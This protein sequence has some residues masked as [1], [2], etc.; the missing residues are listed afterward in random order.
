MS[1][2]KYHGFQLYTKP[3]N[4]VTF[5][6]E[7]EDLLAYLPE[8]CWPNML[9]LEISGPRVD[10]LAIARAS[11]SLRKLKANGGEGDAFEMLAH[12]DYWCPFIQDITL[13]TM[14]TPLRPFTQADYEMAADM[15]FNFSYL[16]HLSLEGVKIDDKGLHFLLSKLADAPITTFNVPWSRGGEA[17]PTKLQ[18]MLQSSLINL[19]YC[20]SHNDGFEGFDRVQDLSVC[21][22]SSDEFPFARRLDTGEFQ[23]SHRVNE[24]GETGRQAFFRMVKES[25][26]DEEREQYDR[27][28][29]GNYS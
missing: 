14:R 6:F 4:R 21:T 1:N 3:E 27:W 17:K 24:A 20:I 18:T 7:T 28:R 15:N 13:M 10:I 23:F 2:F 25:M 19:E 29:Q 26:S 11:P 5:P 8:G 12:I 9:E 16:T 22:K